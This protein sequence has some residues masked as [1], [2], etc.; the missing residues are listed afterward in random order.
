MTMFIRN[1]LIITT[2]MTGS[3]FNQWFYNRGENSN[4][5]RISLRKTSWSPQKRPQPISSC[6]S[7]LSRTKSH[8]YSEELLLLEKPLLS[9]NS[10]HN[11]QNSNIS[12]SKCNSPSTP[13][14][15]RSEVSSMIKSNPIL[16]ILQI[17]VWDKDKIW[18]YPSLK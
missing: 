6:W 18:C 14:Q 9:G 7:S 16:I 15:K 17:P 4:T 10:Y 11:Y 8:C 13:N 3:H 12:L 5:R 2:S 1:R